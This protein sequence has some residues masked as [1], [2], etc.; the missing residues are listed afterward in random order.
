MTYIT[1]PAPKFNKLGHERQI[2]PKKAQASQKSVGI[3]RN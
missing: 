1:Y 3:G 2:A